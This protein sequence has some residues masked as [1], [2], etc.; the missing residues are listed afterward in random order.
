M[1]TSIRQHDTADSARGWVFQT[2]LRTAAGRL[3]R[4]P[5]T[6]KSHQFGLFWRVFAVNGVILLIAFA[7]LVLT[8]ITVSS[9]TTSDQLLV[10]SAGLAV[11]LV[12]NAALLRFSLTP[13]RRLADQMGTVDVLDPGERLARSG[14]A[15]VATVIEAFNAA[16]DRLEAERRSSTRRVLFAQEAERRRIA[17][18]LHDQ[19]GQDL[20]AVVL[21]LKRVQT[22]VTAEEAE[23]LADAQE[24]ARESLEDLRRISHQLRPVA[25]D[26][27]GLSSAIAALCADITRRTEFDIEFD[28]VAGTLPPIDHDTELAI[29][30]IAQE[31][32]TNAVRH[33]VGTRVDVTLTAEPAGLVLRV[34]DNGR[35]FVPPSG[36]GGI[37]G[38]RERAL[39]IG[40]RLTVGSSPDGGGAVTLRLPPADGATR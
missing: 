35:G 10:L 9:P 20:T 13:L 22:R 38:M 15:E 26:D 2:N 4:R 30:R 25:L 32:I 14:T 39:A 1:T 16:L 40:G 12:A 28:G 21:E 17:Q 23:T 27:L 31:S 34:A 11:M 29:Y 7:L 37:R 8:P 6:A 36:G 19:I 33:S 5:V 24:L 18:E 3:A